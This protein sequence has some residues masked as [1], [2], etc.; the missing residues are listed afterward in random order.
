MY[1]VQYN[2][3]EEVAKAEESMRL[4]SGLPRL[5]RTEQ[6]SLRLQV[7]LLIVLYLVFRFF[8]RKTLLDDW[9]KPHDLVFTVFADFA[10]ENRGF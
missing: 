6:L 2:V 7:F 1:F 5:P 4:S 9:P 10:A 3:D 8:E